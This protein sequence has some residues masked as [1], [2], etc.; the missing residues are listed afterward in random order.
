MLLAI[1]LEI[2]TFRVHNFFNH[3]KAHKCFEIGLGRLSKKSILSPL[4]AT[5]NWPL[6][7]R[8]IENQRKCTVTSCCKS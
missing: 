3:F 5:I 8:L 4:L 6:G 1:R 2:V 7:N